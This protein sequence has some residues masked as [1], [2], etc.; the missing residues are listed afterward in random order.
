[1]KKILTGLAGVAA[2]LVIGLNL[3]L[4]AQQPSMVF[5]PT[6]ELVSSPKE[7]GLAYEDVYL[8]SSNGRR[9]HGWFV[10]GSKAGKALLFFHGNGGNISYRNDSLLIFNRLG[11]SVLVIDYQGYG[12]SGGS[13]GEEAMYADGRVA[14]RY[15]LD[16]RGYKAKNIVVFGR[17]LGGAVAARIG[18]ETQPRAVILESTFSSTSD[19]AARLF[20]RL[21]KLIVM[22]YRFNT[23]Q[24][25]KKI[26]RPLLVLHSRSDEIIPFELGEKVYAA[27]NKP[28]LFVEMV[29][30]H[31]NGF[32]KSQPGYQDLLGRFL[33]LTK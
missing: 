6:R 13:P 21:S 10:P 15:L 18:A 16:T 3:F 33:E 26:H 27:A 14:F 20:P 12:N 5:F 31:N 2:A 9:I 24:Q 1:M 11:L 25:V 7:V 29:G 28:K 17:S 30:D 32:L 23:E 8:D 22:R 4:Y 19:M